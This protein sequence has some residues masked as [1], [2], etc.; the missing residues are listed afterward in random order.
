MRGQVL[1]HAGEGVEVGRRREPV[2]GG[3]DADRRQRLLQGLGPLGLGGPVAAVGD[4]SGEP[5]R[6]AAG[7]QLL[8]GLGRVTLGLGGR[9]VHVELLVTRHGRRQHRAADRPAGDRA[10][11][12]ILQREVVGGVLDRLAAGQ[13]GERRHLR[14][15]V[16][17]PAEPGE[18]VVR[19]R[20]EVRAGEDLSPRRRLHPRAREVDLGV[21]GQQPVVHVVG[22]HVHVDDDLAGQLR[23][24]R[25]LSGV[26]VLVR[27]Q[28][29]RLVQ[30][31]ALEL[32][33]AGGHDVRL[34]ARAGVLV[35]RHRSALRDRHHVVE[36][37]ERVGQVEHDRRRVRRGDSGQAHQV[38]G[39]VLVGPGV[40]LGV[41][42][43]QVREVVRAVGQHAAVE[44]ALDRV[45][46]VLGGDRRAVLE[47]DPR[48][49][50][51]GPGQAVVTDRAGR[52]GKAGDERAAAGAGAV[53]IGHQ[54]L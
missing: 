51:V 25:V 50:V 37:G 26:P 20:L 17:E 13:V 5:V 10:A 54:G 12:G 47:L 29:R 19:V 45:L 14:V 42:A 46:D 28:Y 15:D 49:K 11:V 27:D 52:G 24:R 40:G 6:L 23:N 7:R 2:Q 16:E 9:L 35:R 3:L 4:T 34:V 30:L 31:V 1:G 22:V 18:R 48:L 21:A 8:L 32:V 36:F 53:L 38:L 44:G 33:R 41:P 39:P 43:Q